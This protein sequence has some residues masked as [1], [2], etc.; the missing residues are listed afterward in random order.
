MKTNFK[1]LDST[2]FYVS[3]ENQ[4]IN[5]YVRYS[6]SNKHYEVDAGQFYFEVKNINEMK[7]KVESYFQQGKF[8]QS[9]EV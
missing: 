6:K 2:T 7:Q 4:A 3:Y 1:K 8:N 9:F 5:V